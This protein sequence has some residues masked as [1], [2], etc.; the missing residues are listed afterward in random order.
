MDQD[1]IPFTVPNS[2]GQVL[3]EDTSNPGVSHTQSR[4]WI[5]KS[6]AEFEVFSTRIV[7]LG[8][9]APGTNVTQWKFPDWIQH[10]LDVLLMQR[11]QL[12]REIRLR[13]DALRIKRKEGSRVVSILPPFGG[14]KFLDIRSA[15]LG[16]E[17]IWSSWS[18]SFKAAIAPWPSLKEMKWE[19]DDRAKTGVSR[20]PPL[21]REPGNLTV[22]WHQLT[23][24]VPY[25]LDQV[26][27]I[28]TPQTSLWPGDADDE[29][30]G[31][32][33]NM[34]LWDEINK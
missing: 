28:P 14:R 31:D 32:G 15:V 8:R 18:G 23:A 17:T 5:S 20:F 27:K 3:L 11:D 7:Q 4:T 16:M 21:P 12:N 2:G 1:G 25:P 29:L 34:D 9:L 22:A 6:E 13:E 19:G 24:I 30:S 26:R 10:R 33:I